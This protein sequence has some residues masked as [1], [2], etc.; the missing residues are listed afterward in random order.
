MIAEAVDTART[1]AVALLVWIAVGAAVGTCAVYAVAVAV[2]AAWRG[3]SGAVRAAGALRALRPL[4]DSPDAPEGRVWPWVAAGIPEAGATRGSMG[5]L[6]ASQPSKVPEPPT[7][8]DRRSVAH[9]PSWART[10][11]DAA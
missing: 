11:E 3:L 2:W 6:P 7:P 4:P 5:P 9:T 1:L 10:E 8:A